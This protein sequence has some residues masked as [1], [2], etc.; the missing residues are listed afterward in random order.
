MKA[1]K[2]MIVGLDAATWDLAK[3]WVAEGHMPNLAKLMS[4][5]TS[6]SLNRF[7]PRSRPGLDFIY[8]RKKPRQAWHFPLHGDEAR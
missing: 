2:V 4:E 8:D 1:P 3:P 7:F 5:G 6:G